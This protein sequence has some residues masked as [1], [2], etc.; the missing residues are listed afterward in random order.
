M[1]Q[2][3]IRYS[4]QHETVY[5]IVKTKEKQIVTG[6]IIIILIFFQNLTTTLVFE[7]KTTFKKLKLKKAMSIEKLA[8]S[9]DKAGC[10]ILAKRITQDIVYIFCTSVVYHKTS[11]SNRSKENYQFLFWW[12]T[13]KVVTFCPLIFLHFACC[14]RQW[15]WQGT[16]YRCGH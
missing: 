1:K 4:Y 5:I 9:A 11:L 12:K 14:L 15:C 7:C 13:V 3:K 8:Q 2:Y 10:K 6:N 16:L